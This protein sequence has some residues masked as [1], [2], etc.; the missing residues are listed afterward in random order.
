MTEEECM[1]KPVPQMSRHELEEV[2]IA[3]RVEV[4]DRSYKQKEL[5]SS[6]REINRKLSSFSGR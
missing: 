1:Y 4:I 6:L 5:E 3:L 2:V